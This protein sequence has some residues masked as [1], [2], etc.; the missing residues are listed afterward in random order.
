[1]AGL[2]CDIEYMASMRVSRRTGYDI[3]SQLCPQQAFTVHPSKEGQL[4]W[5]DFFVQ[6]WVPQRFVTRL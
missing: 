4:K 2:G 6:L 1:M 3:L 5:E